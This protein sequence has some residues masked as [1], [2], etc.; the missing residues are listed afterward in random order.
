MRFSLE[1]P[2][3][4]MWSAIDLVS[5][6][7][8]SDKQESLAL[9]KKIFAPDRLEFHAAQEV[10]ALC[11]KIDKIAAIDPKFGAQIYRETFGFEMNIEKETYLSD[12]QILPLTSN[13]RQDYS[14]ARY[15]L[16]EYFGSFLELHPKHAVE[17]AVRGVEAY[18]DRNHA[19]GPNVLDTELQ[20][21]G[22]RVRLRGDRSCIWAHDPESSHDDDARALINILLRH[23]KSAD[24]E[25]AIRIAEQLVDTSCL[26]VFWSRLFLA[27]SER[28]DKLLDFCLPIAM[29]P[30]FLILQ[31]TVNDAVDVIAKGYSRLSPS[32]RE[33]LE[34]SVSKF[35]FS[36]FSRPDDAR[37]SIERRLFGAIG[38]ANLATSHARAVT[39]VRGSGEST[40][41]ERPFVVKG[42][43]YSSEPFQWIH[44]LDR[45]LPANRKLI[46]A[47]DR[48]ECALHLKSDAST[49][50]A[51]TLEDCLREM[52][53]L[54]SDVDHESQDSDL[55]VQAEGQI[56]SCIC[57]LV[58]QNQVPGIDDDAATLRFKNLLCVAVNS[59]EPKL[60]KDTEANFED[61][62]GWGVPAPRVDAAKAALELARQRPDLYHCLEPTIDNLLRDSHPAV[63][64]EAALHLLSIWEIDRAGFWQRLSDRL[65]DESNQ[66]VIDYLCSDV[67]RRTL[68]AAPERTEQSVLALLSRFEH[69]PER[70]LRT[71][72]SASDLIAILWVKH[73]LRASHAVLEGWIDDA[74][75]HV[76]GAVRNS[77]DATPSLYRW[78]EWPSRTERREPAPSLTGDC[79]QYCHRS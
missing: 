23:L 60:H 40:D 4:I 7:Y 65:A 21:D 75:G 6:T 76:F 16:K 2:G 72:K 59:E 48:T 74:V 33:A 51:V 26:A 17:A 32:A 42:G 56:A 41:D 30:E 5:D 1:D 36:R 9:L 45:D 58:D 14:M 69:E 71:R 18:V 34:A 20:V 63:R 53:A 39:R 22:R 27:A 19:P 25:A 73:E 43:W 31:D 11:R 35:D 44:G 62:A 67:L 79:D 50:I 38:E 54:V 49:A 61:C 55:I 13:M 28:K 66:G 77:C 37:I 78:S 47:I 52:E 24:E 29:Q 46:D 15:K 57:H 8:A 68:H 12:S 10:P 64:L 3:N 70:Q